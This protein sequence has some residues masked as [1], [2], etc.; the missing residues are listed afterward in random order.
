MARTYTPIGVRAL[1]LTVYQPGVEAFFTTPQ[2]DTVSTLGLSFAAGVL[3]LASPAGQL[4]QQG[5]LAG[6]GEQ[7][8][9][10]LSFTTPDDATGRVTRAVAS[11]V[12]LPVHALAQDLNRRWWWLGADF[13][14][15][16]EY[17]GAPGESVALSLAGLEERPAVLVNAPLITGFLD[18]LA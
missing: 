18:A 6:R 10:K 15:Q 4:T 3:L 2:L 5:N 8:S 9:Q 14:L 1:L 7:V 17:Q 12:G 13:G 11:L 16:L